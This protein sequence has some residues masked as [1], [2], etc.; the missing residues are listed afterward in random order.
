MSL[1]LAVLDAVAHFLNNQPYVAF[2]VLTLLCLAVFK[3][4]RRVLILALLMSTLL[5]PLIKDYYAVAR[6]C[7]GSSECPDTFGFPSQHATMASAFAT[8]SWGQ[9]VNLILIPLAVF[10]GWTRLYLGVHT[11]VQVSAGMALGF[12][13]AH[14]SQVIVAAVDKRWLVG[15]HRRRLNSP[16]AA[17]KLSHE[18]EVGR[19]LIHILFGLFFVVVGVLLGQKDY[20]I[21]LAAMLYTGMIVSTLKNHHIRIPVVD[22]FLARFERPGVLPG[23]GVVMYAAGILLLFSF[24]P[25]QTFALGIAAI[26]ALGDGLAT[27]FG[28][29]GWTRLPW[30]TNKSVRGTMA[31]FMGGV[32]AGVWFLG[33][34]PAIFYSA[35][36]AL[37]ESVDLG[38]DD[39]ILIPAAGIVLH[40]MF[41]V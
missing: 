28:Q 26:L 5:T 15:K 29:Y 14:L 31:F 18:V 30:N 17:Y 8:S 38:I 24:A 20:L 23:K 27:L 39:N 12:L 34:G 1:E 4:N 16:T 41:G 22:N 9:W 35:F 37:A 40:A 21:L 33:I 19:Q 36:L 25:T 13:F 10:I 2:G 11:F 3:N 6:P 7:H 32:V